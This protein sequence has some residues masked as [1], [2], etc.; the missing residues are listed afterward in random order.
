M[1]ELH[2]KNGSCKL[3]ILDAEAKINRKRSIYT[4]YLA[5]RHRLLRLYLNLN[6]ACGK[7]L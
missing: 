4:D 6:W 2:E 5:E 3:Q 7:F 1:C